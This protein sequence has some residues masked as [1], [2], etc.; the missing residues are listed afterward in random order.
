MSSMSVLKARAWK[1]TWIPQW[2][3]LRTES[4]PW[5]S[6]KSRNPEKTPRGHR[7]ST[8]GQPREGSRGRDQEGSTDHRDLPQGAAQAARTSPRDVLSR[9]RLLPQVRLPSGLLSLLPARR[10]SGL[11]S[12]PAQSDLKPLSCVEL[13]SS[14][15]DINV[16]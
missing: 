12:S 9:L 5:E 7:V 1:R 6:L 11:I 10:S 4:V 13:S 8:N 2:S 14:D 16:G 3:T 15:L